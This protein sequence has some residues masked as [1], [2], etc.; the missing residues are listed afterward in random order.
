MRLTSR[1]SSFLLYK[2]ICPFYFFISCFSFLAAQRQAA[3]EES[4]ALHEAVGKG[5]KV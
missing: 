3:A 5:L 1:T 4:S 2:L